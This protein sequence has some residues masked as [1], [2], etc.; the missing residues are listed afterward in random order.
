[1]ALEGHSKKQQQ[2]RSSF[3]TPL[4]EAAMDVNSAQHR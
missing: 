1:M 3:S 2:N 4:A